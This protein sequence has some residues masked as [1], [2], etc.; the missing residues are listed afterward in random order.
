MHWKT[1]FRISICM[2]IAAVSSILLCG[3]LPSDRAS[4]DSIIEQQPISQEESVDNY[5]YLRDYNGR[6]GVYQGEKLLQCTE[7]PVSSL[8]NSDQLLIEKGIS[9]DSWDDLLMLLEDFGS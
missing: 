2:F 5:Y 8:R 1:K 9:T 7:I 4:A 6:I 3:I